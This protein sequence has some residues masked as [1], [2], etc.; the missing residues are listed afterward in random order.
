MIAP[1]EDESS[2]RVVPAWIARNDGG[3]TPKNVAKK[4]VFNGTFTI[5]DVILINQLGKKGVMRR[6]TI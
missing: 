3:A 4:K 2:W 6:N 5:G 1:E